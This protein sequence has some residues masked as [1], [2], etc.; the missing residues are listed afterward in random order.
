MTSSPA[1]QEALQKGFVCESWGQRKERIDVGKWA[2]IADELTIWRRKEVDK[3]Y[4]DEPKPSPL[5]AMFCVNCHFD[6]V[7]I[8]PHHE[9]PV[10]QG[11]CTEAC[12]DLHL[13]AGRVKAT[14]GAVG[15]KRARAE[16]GSDASGGGGRPQG[17]FGELTAAAKAPPDAFT[18]GFG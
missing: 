5:S 18:F 4:P 16:I 15:R 11:F 17:V 8:V 14:S 12:Q 7:S 10:S 2:M 6:E 3:A 1:F 13:E 9:G